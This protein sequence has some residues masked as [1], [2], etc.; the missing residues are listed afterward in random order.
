MSCEDV[1]TASI[2]VL[3]LCLLTC[4]AYLVMFKTDMMW[5]R[6]LHCDVCVAISWAIHVLM[7]WMS[8]VVAVPVNQLRASPR[9]G[10]K[11]LL[12]CVH[13]CGW[14]EFSN[15]MAEVMVDNGGYGGLWW[16]TTVLEQ[17]DVG[18]ETGEIVVFWQVAW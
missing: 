4:V 3:M 13:V 1:C 16:I 8:F 11:L 2:R 15:C 12:L 7:L 5:T 6:V 14:L 17:M 10:S 9:K 18:P